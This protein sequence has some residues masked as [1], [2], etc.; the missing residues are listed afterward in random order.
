MYIFLADETINLDCDHHHLNLNSLPLSNLL[1]IVIY[2]LANNQRRKQI[3]FTY[4]W[5]DQNFCSFSIFTP[6]FLLFN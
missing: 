4:P 6:I 5:M 2:R 3:N 1:S